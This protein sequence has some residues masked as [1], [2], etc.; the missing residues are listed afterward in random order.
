MQ[1]LTRFL[2]PY[3]GQLA[4]IAVLAFGQALLNLYLPN[5][6]ADI[7]DNGVVKGDTAYIWR[8]GAVMLVVTVGATL[9]ALGGMFYSARVGMSFG[10][11]LRDAIFDLVQRF[12]LR[13]FDQLGTSSLI[14]RTTNDTTQVQLVLVLTLGTI[15]SA[16]LTM[17]AGIVLA[18]REDVGL[19]WVL[20]VAVPILAAAIL[21]LLSKTVPL[22][23]QYQD[24]L[25]QLNLVVDEGLTGVRVIRAFNRERHEE[26]RFDRANRELTDLAI[27]VNR[28]L[29]SLWPTMQLVLNTTMVA[30]VWFG[31]Q[32]VAAGELHVGQMMAFL[33][34]AVQIL[35]SLLQVSFLFVT[36]PRAQAAAVRINEVL[37]IEP[38]INDPEQPRPA[39]SQRGWLEFRDVTFSYPGAEAP[40]LSHLS[41]TAAPGQTTAIIGGTGSGKSTLV[42][43]IPRFYDVD[44]GAVLVDGVDVREITQADLRRRIGFVPQKAVLFSGTI[45]ENI[46]YG[47]ETATDAEVQH[48]AEVAQATEFIDDMPDGLDAVIAQGGT[49]VSGGQKQRLAIARALVRK[50]EIYIFD[51]SFSALD[52]KTDAR[53]RA[54]LQRETQEATVLIVSQR[55]STVMNADQIIVLEEGEAC[56]VG[57][58]RELMETCEV[59]R[60]IVTSQLTSA[61]VA[62]QLAREMAEVV[63]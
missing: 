6:M 58:H 55:V 41:F 57:S 49:N 50:P 16:P 27:T 17:V 21:L 54:A 1:K 29:A 45:A 13:A 31:S 5:L 61:E 8:I 62:D 40:A 12:S 19:A 11:D 46:R 56:A 15:L 20:V 7:I 32:R 18:L 51:D 59:Y 4:A 35:F 26:A 22:Y 34:Y 10:K 37:A 53:L 30:I 48:A 24:Q 14:T 38:Q 28:L 3:S 23:G 39:D 25:D 44:S 36:L 43:L 2:R 9:A 52:Y 33:Q 42:N 60:E 47:L 63:A